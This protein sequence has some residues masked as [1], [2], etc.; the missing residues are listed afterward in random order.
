[1]AGLFQV[2]GPALLQQEQDMTQ[3]AANLLR[4][5]SG[6]RSKIVETQSPS[7]K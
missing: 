2:P 1:M 4:P 5:S 7:S 3:L 6:D